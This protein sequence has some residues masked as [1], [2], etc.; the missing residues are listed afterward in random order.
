M[1]E[2]KKKKYAQKILG[3]P[4]ASAQILQY[5]NQ[6]AAPAVM[7]HN[8]QD[9]V[10]STELLRDHRQLSH[11]IEDIITDDST[12]QYVLHILVTCV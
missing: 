2:K 8:P 3:C 1:S 5:S 7:T 11:I 10:T 4:A 12:F 9:S 6:Y